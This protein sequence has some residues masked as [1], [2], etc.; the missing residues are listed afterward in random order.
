MERATFEK[1]A[2]E[3]LDAVYRMACHLTRNP[4]TAQDLVQDVFVRALNPS[5]VERFEDRGDEAGSGGIRSWLFTI[6]HNVFYSHTKR[7]SRAPA[8]VADFFDE[9]STE[10]L[11][12]DP[13]PAWDLASFDWEQVDERL[14][15]AIDDLTDDYREVL[16]LWGVEGLKY[17]EIAE[18]LSVPI[19]TVMSRL[20]RARKILA[21]RIGQDRQAVDD[22]GIGR[23]IINSGRHDGQPKSEPSV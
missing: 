19:G 6:C 4:E 7:E 20:H 15:A 14:K 10:A 13:A 9:Q 22:L 2:L 1:L 21:D 17:R 16:L 23:Q 8:A 11:P 18:I 12:D 5:A 3:H